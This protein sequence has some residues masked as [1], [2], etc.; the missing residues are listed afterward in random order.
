MLSHA[1]HLKI[2]TF[3]LSLE[4]KKAP[5]SVRWSFLYEVLSTFGFHLIDVIA[6]L[7]N[8]PSAKINING[9]LSDSFTL[10]RGT[11]WG[12]LVFTFLMQLVS[13][14][15]RQRP[16]RTGVLMASGKQ[17]PSLFADDLL[18]TIPIPTQ[19]LPTDG[20]D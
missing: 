20:D 17:K 13:Q 6:A 7:Y 9:D 16:D 1:V 15:I 5:D 4:A 14:W 10:G 2:K 11:R 3:V 8:K 19:T 18:F 12:C